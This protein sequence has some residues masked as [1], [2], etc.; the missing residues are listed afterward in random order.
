[1]VSIAVRFGELVFR[2]VSEME[3]GYLKT[4]GVKP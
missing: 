1:M 2:E 3:D 4:G